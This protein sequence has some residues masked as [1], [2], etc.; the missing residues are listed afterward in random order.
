MSRR[1]NSTQQCRVLAEQCPLRT[2]FQQDRMFPQWRCSLL[3]NS[4]Q[5][6]LCMH[7]EWCWVSWRCTSTQQCRAQAEQCLLRMRCLLGKLSPPWCCSQLDNNCQ[8]ALC[9]HS[10]WDWWIQR[11]RNTLQRKGRC[12]RSW[13]VPL[14]PTCLARTVRCRLQC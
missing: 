5:G 3:H 13:S 10:E 6:A 9:M 14:L 4:C 1:S 11:C 12:T 2:R 7:I 8:V